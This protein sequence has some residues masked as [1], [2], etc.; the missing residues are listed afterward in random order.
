MNLEAV[1][2]ELLIFQKLSKMH[3]SSET[4]LV[5]TEEKHRMEIKFLWTSSWTR[6]PNG[7][8]HWLV[9]QLKYMSNN[10]KFSITTEY[11]CQ[12][13][14]CLII[15]HS[16]DSMGARLKE[17]Y[18]NLNLMCTIYRAHYKIHLES[19]TNTQA[20]SRQEGMTVNIIYWI[21][22]ITKANTCLNYQIICIIQRHMCFLY[23]TANGLWLRTASASTQL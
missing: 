3:P 17:F 19:K 7:T 9:V 6:Y 2:L 15:Q 1:A 10:K 22:I 14:Y 4:F 11:L 5:E 12:Y 23:V 18:C 16:S 20:K 13:R 21:W 8:L